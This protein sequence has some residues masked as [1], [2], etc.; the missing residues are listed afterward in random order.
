M[1]KQIILVAFAASL[2]S[3][4]CTKKYCSEESSLHISFHGFEPSEIDTIYCT[5]YE[6]GSNLGKIGSPEE[7]DTTAKQGQSEPKMV[8]VRRNNKYIPFETSSGEG[9]PDTYEWKVYIPS[10]NRTLIID[11][12]GYK[13]YKC[14]RCFPASPP[15]NKKRSLSTCSVNGVE[16]N[17]REIKVYK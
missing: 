17:V 16:T 1:K 7:T 15:E 5:G 13:T 6:P 8:L 4:C 10:V 14:N 2:L 9:L 11:N 12:Y 3:G